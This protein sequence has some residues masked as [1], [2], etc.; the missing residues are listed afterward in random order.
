MKPSRRQLSACS[1]SAFR[2]EATTNSGVMPLRL[3][4]LVAA[5]ASLAKSS[6]AGAPISERR[7]A[8]SIA[9][10]AAGAS[11]KPG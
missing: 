4:A 5:S 11:M 7:R 3:S 10:V 9:P 6:V 8:V 1:S 2:A